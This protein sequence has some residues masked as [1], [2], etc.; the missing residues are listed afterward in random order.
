MSKRPWLVFVGLALFI[1]IIGLA[2]SAGSSATEAPAATDAPKSLPTAEATAEPAQS[3]PTKAPVSSAAAPFELDSNVYSHK[4]GAFSFNPPAGWTVD[5]SNSGVVM[6]SPDQKASLVFTV[7]NTGE[8]LDS[9]GVDNFIKATEANFF[10]GRPDYVQVDSQ[11]NDAGT[12]LVKKTFTF[13]DVPQ[14]VFTIYMKGGP[15]MF[16][17]D[18]WADQDVADSYTQSFMD[19]AGTINYDGT[20]AA[21]LPIY[22]DTYTFTDKNNTFQFD[23]PLAWTYS[24]DEGTNYYNDTFTSP[25][26]NSLIDSIAYDDGTTTSKAQAGDLALQILNKWYTNGAN[27]IKITGDKVQSDGSE[28]LTWTSKKGGY[29]GQ[30]F[31]ET[32]GTTFLM[33]S[34]IVGNGYEEMFGP[35]FDNTLAT[36]SIPQ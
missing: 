35:V 23:V 27:D 7:T 17:F 29:S 6:T 25:D 19:L 33:L 24:Y 36:Y 21:D 18:F 3:L 8:E 16:A 14:Y 34:W 1:L 30:S 31:F 28:R 10:S 32:R 22:G 26:S 5:E 20:K 11:T 15:A 13:N 4:S 12:T 9:K 2:C